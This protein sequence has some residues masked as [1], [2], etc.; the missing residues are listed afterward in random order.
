[1][2][3]RRE[4]SIRV[5]MTVAA[6]LVAAL[7]C[8]MV[9]A[10]VTVALRG[11]AQDYER[12]QTTAAALRLV[13]LVRRGGLPA[14]PSVP[15]TPVVQVLN[16]QDR[17]VAATRGLRGEPIAAFKP[18]PADVYDD[19]TLCP[20]AGL[21]GCM[22]VVAFRVYQPDGDWTVYTADR[23]VPW[24]VSSTLVLVLTGG[25]LVLVAVSALVTWRTVTRTLAPVDAI[26]AELAEISATSS[27]RRVPLP[28]YHDE[29]RLL[30]ETANATLDR[31]DEALEQQ[32]RFTSD[33]SHDL[34]SPI[35]AAR[36]Q[37]EEALL[38]PD[39]AD[40]PRVGRAVLASLERLQA[41][42]TDLLE[43]ARLDV[44]DRS[45]NELVDLAALVSIELARAER[46][47]L[48]VPSLE[49]GVSVFGDRLRLARLLT[50]LLDN[51]ERHAVERI[52][53]SV[54]AEGGTAV[55]EIQDDGDGIEPAEREVVFQRFARLRASRDRDPN[56]T[57]LG[58]P[59]A[60]QIAR[61]HSGTL[62]IE[63]SPRGARF[64]LRLPRAG[65]D[66]R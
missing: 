24:Y 51:A 59:I 16:A 54:R 1:M 63:D 48:I 42:V 53:V 60:R 13:Y 2:I 40:W 23:V 49:V 7:I 56:G 41:I 6:A 8:F 5:R 52:E 35:A 65:H 29:I 46:A 3:S 4:W 38:Y 62:T 33:A 22:N 55:L 26:R 31:L 12:E 44:R 61:N 37:I 15:G 64:V 58:L 27:G 9:S 21:R 18:P 10:L 14:E 43:L 28:D 66:S 47:K 45:G 36:A 34:R 39:Q 25:G 30:A 50:N 19:R 20:P 11:R 17:V 57:G 32:R